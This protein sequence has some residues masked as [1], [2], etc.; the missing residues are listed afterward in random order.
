MIYRQGVKAVPRKNRT[1]EEKSAYDQQ[2]MHDHIIRK[3]IPFNKDKD[4]DMELLAF[5][6]SKGPRAFTAY[7]KDLIR[8]DMEQSSRL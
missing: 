5:A 4:E 3:L 8:Q 6:E 7:I 1:P 2:Y